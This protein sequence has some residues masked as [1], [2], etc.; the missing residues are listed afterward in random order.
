MDADCGRD[1]GVTGEI[2]DEMSAER[3]GV[4]GRHVVDHVEKGEEGH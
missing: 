4:G 3:D 1:C 2:G